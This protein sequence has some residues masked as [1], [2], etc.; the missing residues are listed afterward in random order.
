MTSQSKPAFVSHNEI[1]KK[2]PRPVLKLCSCLAELTL[3]QAA[4]IGLLHVHMQQA[5]SQHFPR[6]A[7]GAFSAWKRGALVSSWQSC[8]SWNWDIERI[9]SCRGA[10]LI[11]SSR[12]LSVQLHSHCFNH[13]VIGHLLYTFSDRCSSLPQVLD[14]SFLPEFVQESVQRSSVVRWGSVDLTTSLSRPPEHEESVKR[15]MNDGDYLRAYS[16]W[17]WPKSAP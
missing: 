17:I 3:R 1:L 13:L 16:A 14:C 2:V 11:S 8:K 4:H 10:R 7:S 12:A 9:S 6:T 5:F 15:K